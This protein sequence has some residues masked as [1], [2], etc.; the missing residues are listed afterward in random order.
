MRQGFES[1][2]ARFAP[3]MAGACTLVGIDTDGPATSNL[4]CGETL[5]IKIRVQPRAPRDEI[6]ER[7]D[8]TLKVKTTAL[9]VKG[10]ANKA[11]IELLAK[12]FG[13]KK[14]NVKIVA[15][16]ESRDKLIEVEQS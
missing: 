7:P 8:G 10:A 11:C 2:P 5:R 3:Q 4:K 15:G 12:H 6:T 9:P 16:L 1:P 14:S 13:V